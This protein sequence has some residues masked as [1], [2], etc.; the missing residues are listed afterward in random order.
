MA[1]LALTHVQELN[2]K[3]LGLRSLPQELQPQAQMRNVFLFRHTVSDKSCF[4][5]VHSAG[6]WSCRRPD[7]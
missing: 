7:V 6:L 5:T 3:A 2:Q 1:V 4:I